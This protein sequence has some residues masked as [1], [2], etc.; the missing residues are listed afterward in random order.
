MTNKG[1]HHHQDLWRSPTLR[2]PALAERALCHSL[3]KSALARVFVEGWNPRA[4]NYE[5]LLLYTI[6]FILEYGV[7]C[8]Y[9]YV[10]TCSK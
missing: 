1:S 6:L 7:I 4:Q 10:V 3:F 5:L 8:R 9:V 2:L